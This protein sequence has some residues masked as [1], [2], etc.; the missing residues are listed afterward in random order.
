[1]I[2]F[3][4]SVS[5]KCIDRSFEGGDLVHSYR[6]DAICYADYSFGGFNVCFCAQSIQ[7][8]NFTGLMQFHK[9]TLRNVDQSQE[10]KVQYFLCD[11]EVQKNLPNMD[12]SRYMQH[13]FQF[14][15]FACLG[16]AGT[17]KYCLSS[18]TSKFAFYVSEICMLTVKRKNPQKTMQ[19]VV[20]K[21]ID[22]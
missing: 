8:S 7:I 17:Q 6:V 5:L 20:I 19:N 3:F 12:E 10:S 2:F 21:K 1:M 9:F 22:M 18:G 14:L 16:R 4:I 11:I 13:Y 15:L